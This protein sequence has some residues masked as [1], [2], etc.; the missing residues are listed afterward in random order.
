MTEEKLLRS[1]NFLKEEITIRFAHRIRQFQALPFILTSQPPLQQIYQRYWDTF[2]AF[3]TFPPI[4]HAHVNRAF[5]E[6]V[7]HALQQHRKTLPALMAAMA[8]ASSPDTTSTTPTD[9]TSTSSM[10]SPF[11]KHTMASQLGCRVLAYHHLAMSLGG[12][13]G[14]VC[15]RMHVVPLLHECLHPPYVLD[16]HHHHRDRDRDHDPVGDTAAAAATVTCFPALLRFVFTAFLDQAQ[17]NHVRVTVCDGP[18]HV[19]VRM[20]DTAG[21][22]PCPCSFHTTS[23]VH[24]R[25]AL[26]KVFLEYFGGHLQC[27]SMEGYGTDVY[28]T[29]DKEGNVPEGLEEEL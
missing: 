19:L 25:C 6:M 21:G 14:M 15:R 2:T 18:H 8:Q 1:A 5:C 22:H 9:T 27:V 28:I 16:N 11:L 29:L 13:R 23:K 17:G 12:H 7:Q 24:L 3:R 10:L 4:R 20:S 26:S